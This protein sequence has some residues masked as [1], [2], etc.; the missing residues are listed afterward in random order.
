M[1][2]QD[3]STPP[4]GL[5]SEI[6]PISITDEMKRSYLDYAMSVIVSRAL[7]DVRD[8]LKPV[9]RRILYS[10]HENGYEWNKPYR[11]SARVVGDVM[12]KYHPHGDSAIYDAL[13]RLAQ[14]FSM[15]L[16][17]INGQGNFGSV[18]GDRAAAMRYTECRLE[19]VAQTQL[20][21]IDKDTVNFNENYDGSETEPEVLPARY[22][23]LLVNGAGGIAVG[24][25]TNIPPH[26]MGEVIDGTIAM[27]ERPEISLPELM[28]IIP[29]PDF[30]TG[31][32]ILG[33]AGIKSAYETGRGSVLMRSRVETEEIRSGR[34]ALIVTEI[35]Y[36][37]NK[38]SMIEKIAELV[39]EKRVEGISDIRDESDR[40]GMRVVIELKRDAVPDVVLNQLFRYSQ[41]QQ[42]FG[43]NVVALN[44]GRPEQLALQD[45]LKAFI[46]FRE[47]VVGRRTRF[48]LSKARD[49][50]H[51][52]VGLAVATANIDDVIHLIRTAPDPA[53]ARRQLMERHW[54]AKDIEPLIQLIDDPRYAIQEDGTFKL[55]ED[56]ARAIL[57]LRLQRLTAIG[58]D[59]IAEELDKLAAE[60]K[61]YLDILRSRERILEIVRTELEEVR[62]EFATPRRTEITEG[63]GDLDD[64]D[65]IQREDMVVTV[66]HT[67][68]I[69]RV[70]LDTYRA[71][72]RGGKG[73]SGMQT[74]DEDFVTRLFVANTHT[75]VLFFSSRGIAYKMK[76]WRLPLASPQARGNALVNM[77][78]LEQGERI[79]SILPLP[80]DEETWAELD[81]MFATKR[82]TVRR[83]KLSDFAQINK[84]GKIA[85]KLDEGDGIVNVM[86]STEDD[87]VLLTTS[88]G[89]CIRF[90]T[91]DVRVFSGRNSV[92]VRGINLADDDH[93][94][95]M[96]ILGHFE[97]DAEE[98]TAYLKLSRALRGEEAEGEVSY[99]DAG[100]SKERFE[101]MDGFEQIILTISE[102]GYGKRTSSYEYRT[103]GRGGKGI[104]AMTVNDRN[105]RLIAS[106]R[107]EESDEIM[108]VT[109]GGQL[110][111]CPV[112]GIRL[113]GRSTQG[114]IVFNTSAEEKVVAVE[115][116]SEADGDDEAE[117]AALDGAETGGEVET[118]ATDESS[119]ETPSE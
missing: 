68:Y 94:I 116:I 65:L 97:C 66:S 35:P 61:D 26:N 1:A 18:D 4:G 59:E 42:S 39:R 47:E 110:I 11:K 64:E 101:E 41:L 17:L 87:D 67:G 80:E 2:D 8:G 30:P 36:Q 85:M 107:S 14:S 77:L 53:T 109:N 23:N 88:S 3:L 89:M 71:Q 70:P 79:T 38:S 119:G 29:G 28:E 32:L 56:Q 90:P 9:H 10:M 7:P 104:A 15:R 45:M 21:D 52:L 50:A 13:V 95:S 25:A 74:K 43:C 99:D 118:P 57:E 117:N 81:V 106:F 20:S 19:K 102:N 115:R 22:P 111:R 114:V 83:N 103:T 6:Q 93:V 78:P 84:N 100:V 40:Q 58:R 31:G 33:R 5:P 92:G 54:P 76:V 55:S 51:V 69:K 86:T 108:L 72:R 62:D 113:A 73:R 37:V 112:T 75:P 82:G 96:T 63:G 34:M 24:M 105:G 49:R 48:L 44:G 16:P 12:G 60:I 46:A 98:R 91:T 27:I